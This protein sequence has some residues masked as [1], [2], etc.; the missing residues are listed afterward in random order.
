MGRQED[1][2]G[3]GSLDKLMTQQDRL[4]GLQPLLHGVH[5]WGAALHTSWARLASAAGSGAEAALSS[6]RAT[7]ARMRP[8]PGCRVRRGCGAGAGCG[9]QQR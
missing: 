2:G 9:A 6:S 8:K 3:C 4:T 1:I 5:A 7:P